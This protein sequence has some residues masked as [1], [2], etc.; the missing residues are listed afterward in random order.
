MINYLAR[1]MK[2]EDTQ[3]NPQEEDL[4]KAKGTLQLFQK[5]ALE[6]LDHGGIIGFHIEALK[7]QIAC[8]G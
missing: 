4:A 5:I 1:D 8:N 6:G 2:T 7:T 3:E